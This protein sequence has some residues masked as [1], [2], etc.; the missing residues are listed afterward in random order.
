MFYATEDKMQR[1]AWELK[2]LQLLAEE[3]QKLLAFYLR[4]IF[5]LYL[6][7]GTVAVLHCCT[8]AVL[9]VFERNVS[10]KQSSKSWS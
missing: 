8:V 5:F 6:H 10:K 4:L 9:K 3:S 2:A 1:A 7:S